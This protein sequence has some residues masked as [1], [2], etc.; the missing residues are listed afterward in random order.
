MPF[1]YILTC[2]DGSFYVGSTWDLDRRLSEH[3][4]GEGAEYTRH[5]LPVTLSY[6]EWSFSVEACFIREKQVQNWG[7]AKRLALIT[8]HLDSL[9]ALSKKQFR[10]TKWNRHGE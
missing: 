5:R 8:G 1:I 7:R 9:P 6:W 2:A 4:A 10:R 3:N